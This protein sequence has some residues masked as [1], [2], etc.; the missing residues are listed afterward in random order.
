M[1]RNLCAVHVWCAV[2]VF[3]GAA[4]PAQAYL[5]SFNTP[6]DGYDVQSGSVAG[7]VS[8]YNAGQF[9]LNAGGGGPLPTPI[10]ADSGLWSVTGEVGGYF[11]N[12][13][14]RGL[15]TA[16]APPLSRESKYGARCVHCWRAQW[17]TNR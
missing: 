7:D 6:N 11:S 15:Y 13:T 1:L 12:S 4:T 17:W 16:S 10:M 5:G 9:G 3:V 14:D 2:V 8:Y